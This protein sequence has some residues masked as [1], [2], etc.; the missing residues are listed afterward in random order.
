MITGTGGTISIFRGISL[1]RPSC[2]RFALDN[3]T[4]QFEL[5]VKEPIVRIPRKHG[6]FFFGQNKSRTVTF[7]YGNVSGRRLSMSIPGK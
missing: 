4:A 7:D 6:L 3:K 2:I 1:G 5:P